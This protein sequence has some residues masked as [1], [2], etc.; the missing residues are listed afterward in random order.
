[1]GADNNIQARTNN[2]ALLRTIQHAFG[3]VM[4]SFAPR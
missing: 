2:G 1:M 4:G 3:H